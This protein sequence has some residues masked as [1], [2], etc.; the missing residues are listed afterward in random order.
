MEAYQLL[1]KGGLIAPYTMSEEMVREKSQRVFSE[2]GR[3]YLV[4]AVSNLNGSKPQI[5]LYTCGGYIILIGRTSTELFLIDTHPLSSEL[6]SNRNGLLKVFQSVNS[7]MQLCSWIWKRLKL[8]RVDSEQQQSFS[9]LE[10][11]K[12]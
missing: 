2:N 7:V 12:R 11:V 6:G 4:N 5:G 8:C 9:I 10:P 1:R 3:N